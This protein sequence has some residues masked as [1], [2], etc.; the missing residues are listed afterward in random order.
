MQFLVIKEDMKVLSQAKEENLFYKEIQAMLDQVNEQKREMVASPLESPKME[1][2]ESIRES[3]NDSPDEASQQAL[4]N[5]LVKVNDVIVEDG[6]LQLAKP[7]VE[8][9]KSGLLNK[10]RNR[11]I[12]AQSL[13][14][15]R[16][17]KFKL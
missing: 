7:S 17:S 3:P 9:L 2:M 16:L 11:E 6:D 13:R 5:N 1:R 12:L 15:N 14:Q 4:L 8:I 10:E